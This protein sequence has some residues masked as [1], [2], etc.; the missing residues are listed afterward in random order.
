MTLQLTL[1]AFA[2]LI[3]VGRITRTELS[4][5]VLTCL[6]SPY[7]TGKTFEVRRDESD[8]GALGQAN[9]GVVQ[10]LSALLRPL[11]RDTDRVLNGLPP[12]PFPA[13]PPAPVT[14][15]RVKVIITSTLEDSYLI[16]IIILLFKEILND[17]RVV[18][19]VTRDEGRAKEQSTP[20]VEESAEVN[21]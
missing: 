2:S 19:A 4:N 12:F 21:A 1:I 7:A 18:A 16:I 6:N 17:P 20:S 10:D 14:E 11:I 5:L 3:F 13:D 8:S 15:E 9:W